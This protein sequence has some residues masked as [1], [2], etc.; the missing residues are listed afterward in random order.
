MNKRC[1]YC[2][3]EV[4][5][6]AIKCKH[7]GERIDGAAPLAPVAPAPPPPASQAESAPPSPAGVP[8]AA[9]GAPGSLAVPPS[10]PRK[11]V[12]G[13]EWLYF[14]PVPL[15]L[16]GGCPGLAA[17]VGAGAIALVVSRRTENRRSRV[18]AS[19]GLYLVAATI[20]IGV[21][22]A[23]LSGGSEK[24]KDGIGPDALRTLTT[25]VKAADVAA[26]SKS[27][28]WSREGAARARREV[29]IVEADVL[30]ARKQPDR[31]GDFLMVEAGEVLEGVSCWIPTDEAAVTANWKVG[32]T[33]HVK[34]QL[35]NCDGRGEIYL[36]PCIPF[37]ETTTVEPS[38]ETDAR[39]IDP[40]DRL[41]DEKVQKTF[42]KMCLTR[43]AK[44]AAKQID[45][46]KSNPP[47]AV[48]VEECV[49]RSKE[50]MEFQA[51]AECVVPEAAAPTPEAVGG[52]DIARAGY[53]GV[54]LGEPIITGSMDKDAV[55]KVVQGNLSQIRSC[56]EAAMA[57]EPNIAGQVVVKVVI[58]K[59]GSVTK[60]QVTQKTISSAELATC[61]AGRVGTWKF[62]KSTGA[63]TVTV[64][65][66]FE[67]QPPV[68]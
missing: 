41:Y 32:D 13:L 46:C 17:G 52:R 40:A 51:Q 21:H 8:A 3:E 29:V 4:L 26:Y 62:P 64:T 68:P 60:S 31:S 34:G 18:L 15:F 9:H 53:A 7:C 58:S 11:W 50:V 16:L 1:P 39:P 33:V 36:N 44:Q 2:A 56:Y 49:R 57:K 25:T 30:I 28:D 37:S 38:A 10:K 6:E 55:L 42:S 54:S 27:C 63:G 66:P 47:A 35:K 67:F 43:V 48:T 20:P 5:A 12:S 61:T 59:N 65:L 23:L 22:L 19:I 14:A 45:D 24:Q